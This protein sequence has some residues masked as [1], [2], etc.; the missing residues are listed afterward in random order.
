MR[1]SVLNA[2]VKYIRNKWGSNGELQFYE[3]TGIDEEFK[4]GM[5]YHDELRENILRWIGRVKGDEYIEDAGK[6]VVKNLGILAWL[7]RFASIKT[8]AGKF[9]K[10]YSEIY[11]FGKVGVDYPDDNT[12][13]F[14]LYEVN[15]KVK[16]IKQV[17]LSIGKLYILGLYEV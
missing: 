1:G 6:F 12:V 17:L 11:T 5:Y 16:S 15:S 13:L 8:L 10:N 4:D 2:Y 14:K 7:V 9:P 3:E